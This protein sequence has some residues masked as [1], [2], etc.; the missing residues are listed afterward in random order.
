MLNFGS[1]AAPQ[2]RH[3]SQKLRRSAPLNIERTP[4]RASLRPM[5]M[6][7][8]APKTARV[9]R[10]VR[11][12][13]AQAFER[14]D[15]LWDIEAR[16]TD[17]KPQS[18]HLGSGPRDAGE[19]IH[20]LWLRVTVDTAFNIVDAHAASVATPYPGYCSEYGTAYQQL[21]GLNLLK[22]FR[23]AVRD[24]LAGVAGCTHLTELAGMLPTATI[25]SFAGSVLPTR[26]G[27]QDDET[28]Q[29]PFQ[30]DRCH[31]LRRDGAAVAKYY[32]RW[33]I[34]PVEQS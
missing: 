15:G 23:Q 30:L 29:P 7:L 4:C 34:K 13:V 21:I 17:T 27:H 16:L 5:P 28:S 19:P 8:P 12:I 22:G 20:D 31:A 25:Q 9:P 11:S 6:S 14:D 32:P 3:Q 1:F 24:R 33:S 10:H 26:D 18:I 2:E